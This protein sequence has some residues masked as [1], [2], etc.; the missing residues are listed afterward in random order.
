MRKIK[1]RYESQG[2]C[3]LTVQISCKIISIYLQHLV[4]KWKIYRKLN[5]ELNINQIE[6]EV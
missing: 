4:R 3:P 1:S 2:L 6:R 5:K